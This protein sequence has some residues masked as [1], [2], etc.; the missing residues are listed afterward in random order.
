VIRNLWIK[1]ISPPSVEQNIDTRT[2][3][4]PT[5]WRSDRFPVRICR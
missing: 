3:T 4:A 2:W 5:W 1:L